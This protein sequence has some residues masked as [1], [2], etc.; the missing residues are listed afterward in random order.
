MELQFIGEWLNLRGALLILPP[1]YVVYWLLVFVYRITFHPLAKFPG[2][3]LAGAT[4]WY[5]FYYDI[6][7]IQYRYMWKIEE[8]H[9]KYGPIVRINPIHIHINDPQFLDPIYGSG[10]QKRNLDPWFS[11]A[12]DSGMMGESTLQTVDHQKHRVRKNALTRFFSK[13]AV[14]QLEGLIMDKVDRL[15]DRMANMH[16][17]G[18]SVV[19]ISHAAA[20]LSMDVISSYSLGGDMGCLARDEWAGRWSDTFRGLGTLRPIGRQF[21]TL[22]MLSLRIEPWFVRWF[23]PT[24]AEVAERAK[25]PMKSIQ[26][27]IKAHEKDN[28]AL[29]NT[30]TIFMEI[31]DSDLP[32]QEKSASRLS[33][34]AFLLLGAGTDPL[35]RNISVIM[36]YVLADQAI[37]ERVHAELKSVISRP[38]SPVTLAE[39]EALPFFSACITEGL[40]ITNAVSTRIP[41][42]AHEQVIQYKQWTIPRGTPV[43]QSLYLVH[44]NPDVFPEPKKFNPQRWLDN[45]SLKSR[46]LMA[47]GR[48]TRQCLGIN[49]AYAE[50]LLSIARLLYRFDMELFDV[51]KERDIDVTGDCFNGVTHDDSPGVQVRILKDRLV[52]SM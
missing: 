6:W 12:S 22:F 21:R 40:R 38:D 52:D 13:G 5:E 36:Y 18:K 17:T 20:A 35:T 46:Y 3:K 45:P 43:M 49:L 28:Q 2:P 34:E 7:P 48:G 15:L 4:F 1:L 50:M 25:Y 11:V 19:N 26:A 37:L 24:A 33:T 23:S 29:T 51:V 32:P 10:R 9:Q 39:L 16:R 14:R 42:V 30:R 44:M 27:H 31:L 41:R 47:F 8:L